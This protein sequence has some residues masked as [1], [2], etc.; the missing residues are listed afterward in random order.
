M[1]AGHPV[2]NSVRHLKSDS[3]IARD[4]IILYGLE[5]IAV[6]TKGTPIERIIQEGIGHDN[7]KREQWTLLDQ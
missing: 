7:G 1:G 2:Q 3:S 6:H 4:C 5:K